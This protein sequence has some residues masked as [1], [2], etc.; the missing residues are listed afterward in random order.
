VRDDPPVVPSQYTQV[1]VVTLWGIH[2]LVFARASVAQHISHVQ[3]STAAT[4][5]AGV[6]GNKGGAGVGFVYREATSL[7]FV[8]SHLAA[9]PERIA[10]RGDNYSGEHAARGRGWLMAPG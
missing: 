9:R 5:I 10:Q 6:L 8:T 7:A 3:T 1:A 2:L 4:G